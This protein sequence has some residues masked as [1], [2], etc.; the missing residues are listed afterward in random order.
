MRSLGGG[1]SSKAEQGS[2]GASRVAGSPRTR[3]ACA[4]VGALS[5][6][7]GASHGRGGGTVRCR[8]RG[9]PQGESRRGEAQGG[10]R[11]RL[12]VQQR[13]G[14][15]AEARGG[16]LLPG[17]GW[18][19]SRAAT[20]QGRC[21]VFLR[22]REVRRGRRM[23]CTN[24][25]VQR[26]SRVSRGE[27][28]AGWRC[29]EWHHLHVRTAGS[30][31]RRWPVR[32]VPP[33]LLEDRLGSGGASGMA[34]VWVV[35]G[36]WCL[37]GGVRGQPF[38]GVE[39]VPLRRTGRLIDAPEDGGQRLQLRLC[40]QRVRLLRSLP[41][42][43]EGRRGPR[44]LEAPGIVWGARPARELDDLH[45][46][47][48]RGLVCRGGAGVAHWGSRTCRSRLAVVASGPETVHGA[49]RAR[50]GAA[51]GEAA[52]QGRISL[53]FLDGAGGLGQRRRLRSG[54]SARG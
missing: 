4:E 14:L 38:E 1:V 31:Q 16:V 43:L 26:G 40:P 21:G 28:A 9:R 41:P 49:D 15:T 18:G 6:E 11:E 23:A 46:R 35:S 25:R 8:V 36:H 20:S 45:A 54:H 50:R 22:P 17:G 39:V 10:G 37:L 27:V 44:P 48:A 13:G 34:R 29:S 51:R 24:V 19:R 52:Q 12:L 2:G 30:V 47:R 33:V 42:V 7:G 5:R 53:G 3:T 32:R